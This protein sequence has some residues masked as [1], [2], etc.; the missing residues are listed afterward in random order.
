MQLSPALADLH[1]DWRAWTGL[2]RN[3]P[4][5]LHGERFIRNPVNKAK[6]VVFSEEGR[7]ESKE[8][9]EALRRI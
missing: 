6:S 2:D 1:A 4:T 7:E 8:P 3:V 9:P 5:R